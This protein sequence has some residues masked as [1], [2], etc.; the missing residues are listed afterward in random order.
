[1]PNPCLTPR[2]D[3]RHDLDMEMFEYSRIDAMTAER[4][5]RSPRIY[6]IYGFC[7][8]AIMSEFFPHGDM[9]DI[10]VPNNG[11]SFRDDLRHAPELQPRNDL[12]GVEKLKIS[13]Q[14]AEAIADLHGYDE[15]VMVHQDVQLAQFLWNADKTLVKLNDFNRA[16]FLL[17]DDEAEQYCGYHEGPGH[18]NV[19]PFSL[20]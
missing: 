11:Y 13:L 20:Q 5:T 14:M 2:T 12:T 10:A 16:E 6:D 18:G 19:S 7:G 9:E 8:A 17:W 3:F 1:V 15:G 4:L